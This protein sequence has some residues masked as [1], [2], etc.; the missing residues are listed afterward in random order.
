MRPRQRSLILYLVRSMP[1]SVGAILLVASGFAGCSGLTDVSIQ[2]VPPQQAMEISAALGAQKHARHI[3]SCTRWP[4]GSII[5]ET[6]VG[7][8]RA[9][10][11][12]DTWQFGERVI[13][14]RR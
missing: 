13:T 9:V 11:A 5:V 8:Y 2:G 1:R 12:G 4:D 6:D 3:Y 10:H 7:D 14:G